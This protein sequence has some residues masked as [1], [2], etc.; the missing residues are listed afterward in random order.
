MSSSTY[1]GDFVSRIRYRNQLPPLPFPPKLLTLP[2]LPDYNVQHQ[3]TALDY[4]PLPLHVDSKF[5]VQI[6]Q[7]IA[8]YLIMMDLQPDQLLQ[9]TEE[10]AEED[11]VFLAQPPLESDANGKNSSRRPNQNWLRRIDTLSQTFTATDK[12]P[13]KQKTQY[14]GSHKPQHS[15]EER[16]E[17][18]QEGFN[19]PDVNQ[20]VHPRTK[21]KAKR[22]IPLVPDRTCEDTIYTIGQFVADP[23]DEKRLGKRTAG[24][25]Y[26]LDDAEGLEELRPSARDATD[27]G[28]MRPITNPHDPNDSYLIWFLPDKEGT[29]KLVHQKKNAIIGIQEPPSD[30]PITFESVREYLY[31]HDNT[32]SLMMIAPRDDAAHYTIV[33]SRM[34][35]TKKRAVSKAMRYLENYEKPNI[36]NVTYQDQ[37]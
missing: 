36:L 15:F 29:Q 20:L 1:K 13:A 32:Q 10:I 19:P 26:G 35:V 14:S 17:I 24:E 31:S 27:R 3:E 12:K 4:Y 34:T 16:L 21:A 5:G 37:E 23:A 18:V 2:A 11:K 33:K 30:E 28:I 7:P 6:D 22:I 8:E 25:V 9:A